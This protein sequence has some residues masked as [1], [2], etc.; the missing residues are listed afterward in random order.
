MIQ[1]IFW[2]RLPEMLFLAICPWYQKPQ[3]VGVVLLQL[4]LVE[5]TKKPQGIK[6][7][8]WGGWSNFAI[9]LLTETERVIGA[10]CSEASWR[11]SVKSVALSACLGEC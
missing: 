2:T 6:S 9:C 4:S 8:E 5:E 3:K 10:L 11:S 1:N 7:G